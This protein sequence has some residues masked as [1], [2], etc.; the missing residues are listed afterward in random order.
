MR[1]F[2][3][4]LLRLFRG[5]KLPEGICIGKN[6]HMGQP[7]WLDICYGRHITIED[8]ATLAPGVRILCHD[9]SSFRRIGKTWVAPVTIMEGAFIGANSLIM[10][11]VTVGA[12]SVVAAGAVVTHS[13]ASGMV[14]GGVP[15][16]ELMSVADLDRRRIERGG[17]SFPSA[18]YEVPNLA[19]S[20][21]A[22][23][24]EA[25]TQEGGYFLV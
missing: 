23:L 17:R 9:A 7:C 10:P 12:G 11:G 14:V 8:N 4:K 13:V 2:F 18:V 6:V 24:R 16:R 5:P 21:D 22:E 3:S 20:L 1:S 25:V 19:H 15:A